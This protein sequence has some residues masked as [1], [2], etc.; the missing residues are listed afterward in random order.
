MRMRLPYDKKQ[1]PVEIDD[2]NFVGSLESRVETYRP[3]LPS[4][5]KLRKRGK[6]S[7]FGWWVLQW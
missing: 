1:M 5:A 4:S 3:G 7:S 6:A 2:Q